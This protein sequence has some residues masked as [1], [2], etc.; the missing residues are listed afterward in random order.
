MKKFKKLVAILGLATITVAAVGCNN[1]EAKGTSEKTEATNTESTKD[2]TEAETDKEKAEQ[3]KVVVATVEGQNIT[4]AELNKELS[5]LE[6]LLVMQYGEDYKNNE[7]AMKYYKEQQKLFLDY[8]I[9]SKLVIGQ[10]DENKIEVT[11]KEIEDQIEQVKTSV[12]SEEA[13]TA[14]L[15]QEGIT[16]EEYTQL[17]KENLIISKTLEQVTKDVK[18]T[19][20]EV[21]KYYED[22]I[23]QYTQGAGANMAHILVATEDEAK[24]V[25]KEYEE[26]KSFEE[27]AATYGT[28]GTK[29]QGGNLGFITYDSQ[30]YDADFL[31]GAKNLKEGEVSDPVKTQF[32]YHIIKVT[33]VQSEPVV[34][35]FEE[36]KASVEETVLKDKQYQVFEEYIKGIKEKANIEI[37]EDKLG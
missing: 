18:V 12:G 10:A 2:N 30:Q 15:Q 6:Q 27:L 13:F 37:F 19:E 29:D 5:Y 7:E 23:A 14:A 16:L 21:K 9:E 26:G 8:L 11:D 22:N 28:D 31:A 3:E 34:T 35:P 20:D 1:A 25:K 33:G 36:A 24:K 4:L 17:V 32:G